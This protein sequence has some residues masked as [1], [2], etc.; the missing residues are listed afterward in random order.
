MINYSVRGT[1]LSADEKAML[2]AERFSQV[3]VFEQW[4]GILDVNQVLAAN[5]DDLALMHSRHPWASGWFLK[6]DG[7]A[8]TIISN[9][10]GQNPSHLQLT[11]SAVSG[12][13]AQ[14]SCMRN[15]KVGFTGQDYFG[16]VD[17]RL[18]FECILVPET[19]GGVEMDWFVGFASMDG[20]TFLTTPELESLTFLQ[21][22]GFAIDGDTNIYGIMCD[23]ASAE[24]TPDYD[25]TN[26]NT[27]IYLRAV[28]DIGNNV[29]FYVNNTLIGTLSTDLPTV[30][31]N[32]FLFFN[33]I[34]TVEAV[35]K[36]LNNHITRIRWQN[37]AT[38]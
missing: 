24:V 21:R 12:E 8:T 23:S 38:P 13:V 15:Y 37:G 5:I 34:Q 35:D 18:I 7:A 31:T 10:A 36:Q 32:G 22:W 19:G 6:E 16:I 9:D 3:P 33:Y 27:F 28:Y 17:E 25:L 26:T 2:G 29:E 14:I 1:A 4:D 20:D 30:A 11:T